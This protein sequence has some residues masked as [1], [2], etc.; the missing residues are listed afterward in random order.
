M[1]AL[2]AGAAG[3]LLLQ[4][5]P[6]AANAPTD[7]R[8]DEKARTIH[9][10]DSINILVYTV[11]LILTVCLI[12][13]FKRRR[14]R[15]LHE[16][17]L[18]VIFGLMVG[19]IIRYASDEK[20]TSHLLVMPVGNDSNQSMPSS[21]PDNVFIQLE[22]QRPPDASK[23]NRSY[24]Y[25]AYTFRGEL[26]DVMTKKLDQKATF[27]PEIFFNI[28]L[29]PI[30]FN[31]GYSLKRKFFFRNLGTIMTY[32]F[33]GTTISCF[34]V[35]CVLYV[36]TLMLSHLEFTFNHCL[37]FGAIISATD[38]VTV[39]AIFHDLHVDVNLY[40]LVFGESILNDAVAI[41]LV[42]AITNYEAVSSKATGEFEL[43]AAIRAFG[44]FFYIFAFSFLIGS[45]TGCVTALITKF[46]KL[47]DFP[48]LES[49]L[50]LLM[51]YSSFLVAEALDLTGIV[52]VLFCGICQA[53]YTYNNLSPESRQRTKQ[54]FELMNFVAENF[55]FSYIGV[56]MFTYKK[57]HWDLFFIVAAFIS[58]AAG[59][60]LFVYPLTFL[61]NL[62]RT[63]KI[64][65][66]FQHV[67]FFSGLR[68]AMAFALAI[69]NTLGLQRH[70]MLTTTSF[71]VIVSVVVCGG[72]T[73]TL[74]RWL[75]I[76]VGSEDHDQE[77]LNIT[78]AAA[79]AHA[80]QAQQGGASNR[81]G[82]PRSPTSGEPLKSPPYEKAWL[83]RKWYNFDV[84]FMKPFLT[85]SRPTLI[86][87][88]P[89][90]CLPVAHLLTSTEQL[91]QDDSA[92]TLPLKNVLSDS[93]TVNSLDSLFVKGST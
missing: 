18:A 86:E 29:P 64:P 68:G 44:S 72:S 3:A 38:P 50:F 42:V 23:E 80:A 14:A 60:A 46:T 22:V 4:A 71:I 92:D 39:L 20:E 31:A 59:R 83:V 52:A 11:L 53:H 40:A 82:D 91:T 19:A 13:A 12:W 25:Y 34:V 54:L 41:G 73:S 79:A 69:R 84:R 15:F 30:I 76:P 75:N 35:G 1:Y 27:D 62:G 36:F 17:G 37:Y 55:I 51:S 74:L 93:S 10:I 85:H 63:N 45:C 58:I 33:F 67:L 87:T 9:R 43:A 88:L 70:V 78:A 8:M 56:S 61:L 57:H 66:A 89:S 77:L 47:C 5:S 2:V 90:C 81:P 21:P 65:M 16:T 6:C 48:L 7:I 49:C 28:I 32:A 26:T 24:A